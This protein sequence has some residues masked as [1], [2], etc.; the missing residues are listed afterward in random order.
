MS[1]EGRTPFAN[2][3]E[4]DWF[5]S[6]RCDQCVHDH[7]EGG[8]CDEF[9]LPVA[10]GEWPSLLIEVDRSSANPLGVECARFV[11]DPAVVPPSTES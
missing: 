7:P 2:G 3:F 9:T 4:V 11:T 10:M 1:T 6:A 8:G 5:R